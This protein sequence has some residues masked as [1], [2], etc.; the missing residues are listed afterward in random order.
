MGDFRRESAYL[1]RDVMWPESLYEQKWSL[2]LLYH[3]LT[4]WVHDVHVLTGWIYAGIGWE[5]S[6]QE[7]V[8]QMIHH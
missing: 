8:S 4:D 5:S 6:F 7:S 1:Q 3:E 2:V